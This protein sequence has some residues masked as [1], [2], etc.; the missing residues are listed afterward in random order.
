MTA[1]IPVCAQRGREVVPAAPSL[2][3]DVLETR[4]IT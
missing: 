2:A 4:E 3:G 1:V